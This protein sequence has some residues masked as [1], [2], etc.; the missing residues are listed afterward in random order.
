MQILRSNAKGW[1]D[2]CIWIRSA[3][4]DQGQGNANLWIFFNSNEL[5]GIWNTLYSESQL[6]GK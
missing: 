4:L 5:K 3:T 2:W 1:P 6:E